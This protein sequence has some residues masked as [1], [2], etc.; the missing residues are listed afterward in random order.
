MEGSMGFLTSAAAAA[1]AAETVA[2]AAEER[3][4]ER[5]APPPTLS[6]SRLIWDGMRGGKYL[7]PTNISLA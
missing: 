5:K 4:K 2:A 6:L 1:V 7:Y 3:K